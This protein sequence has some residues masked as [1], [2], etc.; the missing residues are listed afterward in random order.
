MGILNLFKK[1][2]SGGE[3]ALGKPVSVHMAEPQFY[4]NTENKSQLA[5]L[6]LTEDCVT[7]LPL[8]PKPSYRVDG[9]E[10]DDWRLALVSITEDGVLGYMEYYSALER[11]RL[12]A[13]VGSTYVIGEKDGHL[14]TTPLT[15]EEMKTLLNGGK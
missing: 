5:V 11:L 12:L 15:L 9:K 3:S 13:D 2:K 4:E 7:A 8:D 1:K 10:I 6:C 14:I